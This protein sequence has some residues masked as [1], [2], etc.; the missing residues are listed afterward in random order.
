MIIFLFSCS[1]NS[2]DIKSIYVLFYNYPFMAIADQDCDKIEKCNPNFNKMI[3]YGPGGDSLGVVVNDS[4]VLDT[5]LTDRKLLNEIKI[6]IDKLKPDTS[7][8]SFDARISC[9]I[10]Y[11][12]G[13]K[14]RLC[15]GGKYPCALLYKGYPQ[16]DN[17]KLVYMIKKNIRYY[18]WMGQKSLVQQ[19]ELNDKLIKRDSV[20]NQ[21][22]IKW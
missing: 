16:K 14:D 3:I 10:T 22:G 5:T 4:G 9:L 20:V 2:N 8:T 11:S 18:Y 1:H 17:N 19:V 6:E 13:K 7:I 12:N 15:I 21:Y